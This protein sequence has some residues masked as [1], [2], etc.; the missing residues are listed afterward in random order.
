MQTV[1]WLRVS[2]C[3]HFPLS[4]LGSHMASLVHAVIAS[5]SSYWV[6]VKQRRMDL[7]NNERRLEILKVRT[8]AQARNQD[9][10][11]MNFCNTVNR[12][13][14]QFHQ[15]TIITKFYEN[16]H[17]GKILY[18]ICKFPIH[19]HLRFSQSP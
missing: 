5:V 18:N 9:V 10:G 11:E 12:R 15:S 17:L 13:T 8:V 4:D 14:I 7:W 2:S 1:S 19:L 6:S 3:V 16:H